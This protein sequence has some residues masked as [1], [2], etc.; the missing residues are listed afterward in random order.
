MVRGSSNLPRPNRSHGITSCDFFMW[1]LIK[2]RAHG[3]EI[4]NITYL[5]IRI[6]GHFLWITKDILFNAFYSNYLYT[7]EKVVEVEGGHVEK[8]SICET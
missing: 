5:K 1:E 7:R 6:R 3:K 4:E 8:N 2:S